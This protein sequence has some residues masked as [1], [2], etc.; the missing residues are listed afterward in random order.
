MNPEPGLALCPDVVS[1]FK[2]VIMSTRP[3]VILHGWSD[4][5]ESFHNLANWFRDNTDR[6]VEEISLADWLSLNDEITYR[7]L[8]VG[9]ER[10]WKKKG[11]PTSKRSADIII[12]STG[13]LVVR[14]W[15]T[16]FYEADSNPVFHLLMLA[17]ANFGSPLAHKGRGFLGRILKGSGTGFQTG[18][19]LLKGLELGSSYTWNLADRDLFT[20]RTYWYGKNRVMATVLVGDT[21][22]SGVSAAANEEGGDG[23]VR[24]STANLNATRLDLDFT[25]RTVRV[26]DVT[27]TPKQHQ[28]GFAI[29]KGLNHGTITMNDP[30]HS[31]TPEQLDLYR[32]ALTALP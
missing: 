12:H 16:E 7:D 2:K 15:M 22:Y 19:Q 18:T 8:A 5:S 24:A 21:G 6:T 14:E 11:L 13:A 30:K 9:M 27:H 32:R 4:S 26:T 28:A 23:T 10:E 25:G 1:S 29:L 31:P 20:G 17:P 3:L